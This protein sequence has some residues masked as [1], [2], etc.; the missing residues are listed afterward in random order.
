MR[1]SGKANKDRTQKKCFLVCQQLG[2]IILFV[3]SISIK[4]L[5]RGILLGNKLW[6]ERW[7]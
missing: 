1:N 2:P 5:F 7:K 6:E 4:F 3:L